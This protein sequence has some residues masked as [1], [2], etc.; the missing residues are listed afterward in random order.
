MANL[1]NAN[2]GSASLDNAQFNGA[3]LQGSNFDSAILEFSNFTDA[4]ISSANLIN[5]DLS[6]V[7]FSNTLYD[8]NT[9]FDAGFDPA[10]NSG[11]I[12]VPEPSSSLLIGLASIFIFARRKRTQ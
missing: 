8:S 4:N 10:S 6:E 1:I 11:L 12:L 7:T 9:V 2:M 3:N 5:V